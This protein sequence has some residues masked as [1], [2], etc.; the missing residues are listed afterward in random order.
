MLSHLLG[1]WLC[2]AGE[3]WVVMIVHVPIVQPSMGPYG[4]PSYNSCS[5]APGNNQRVQGVLRALTK[6]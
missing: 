2:S 1:D 4:V 6:P 5:T 3:F